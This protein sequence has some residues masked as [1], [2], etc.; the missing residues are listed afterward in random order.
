MAFSSARGN[1]PRSLSTKPKWVLVGQQ[2]GAIARGQ[3]TRL[4]GGTHL[5]TVIVFIEKVYLASLIVQMEN[6]SKIVIIFLV[7][8]AKLSIRFRIS[9]YTYVFDGL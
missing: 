1:D 3:V 6:D 4:L 8:M 2:G 9:K 7:I 5:T